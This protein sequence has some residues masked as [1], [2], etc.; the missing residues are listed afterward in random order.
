MEVA[1]YDTCMIVN[2]SQEYVKCQGQG[3]QKHENHCLGNVVETSNYSCM[4]FLIESRIR[5]VVLIKMVKF[6]RVNAK[7]G[8]VEY[9][10][11]KLLSYWAHNV[12]VWLF[13]LPFYGS[14]M[15]K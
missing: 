6:E 15:S 8:T 9:W 5:N 14:V 7:F 2:I 11:I 4:L 13:L 10:S 12:D 1:G 3:H